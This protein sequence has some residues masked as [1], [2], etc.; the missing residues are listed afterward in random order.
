MLHH[1]ALSSCAKAIVP[2]FSRLNDTGSYYYGRS[3]EGTRMLVLPVVTVVR[4]QSAV[5]CV[6]LTRSLLKH[7]IT[8]SS[9]G[10]LDDHVCAN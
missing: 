5:V 1:N 3:P 7:K 4:Y 9:R 8:R 10:L 6:F 2:R